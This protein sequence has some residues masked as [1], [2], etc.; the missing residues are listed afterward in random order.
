MITGLDC[1][2][3]YGD[4]NTVFD[5]GLYMVIHE[6]PE[7]VR[8]HF[9]SIPRRIYCNQE[10]IV[11]LIAALQYILEAGLQ[12]EIKTWDGCFQVRP[13]RGYEKLVK[14]LLAQGK[15]EEAM[16]YMSIHSW[17]VAFDINAAWNGLG[18][19]PQMNLKLVECFEKAGFEWGGRWKRKDGMHYQLAYLDEHNI[20]YK[21]S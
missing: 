17:G 15:I 1:Y 18:K 16:I 13:I 19:E 8:E 5:E 20:L 21:A 3:K 12:E 6:F 2:N 14:E 10:L 4:P 9:P 7:W 11:P